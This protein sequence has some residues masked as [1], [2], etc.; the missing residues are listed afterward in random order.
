[1]VYA[2]NGSAIVEVDD[3]GP[4]VPDHEREQVFEPFHRVE[5]SRSRATGGSGL[6]LAVVRTVARA[7]GG[8]AI[9]ENRIGGGLRARAWLPL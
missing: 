6:G 5:P 3:D 9:I 7:H 1:R 4:G 8:D 2:E